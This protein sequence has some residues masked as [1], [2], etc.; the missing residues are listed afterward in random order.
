MVKS[1]PTCLRLEDSGG[2]APVSI[3]LSPTATP[4]WFAMVFT[5]I[6]ECY[7]CKVLYFLSVLNAKKA[8]LRAV[9]DR[10][11]EEVES[12]ENGESSENGRSDNGQTVED[13][14]ALRL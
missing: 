10:E 4:L 11:V 6:W 5:L 9:R 2:T 13:S 8:K 1:K 7:L 12:T 3:S 14:L